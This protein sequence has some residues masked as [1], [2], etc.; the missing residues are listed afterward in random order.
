MRLPRPCSCTL[1]AAERAEKKPL[2]MTIRGSQRNSLIETSKKTV[3]FEVQAHT[4]ALAVVSD[5]SVA[6]AAMFCDGINCYKNR[7][8][9]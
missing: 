4:A 8:H 3:R 9:S 6:Q 5:I 2:R 7:V 1:Q